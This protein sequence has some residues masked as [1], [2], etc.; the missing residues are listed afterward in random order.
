MTRRIISLDW[1]FEE[2]KRIAGGFAQHSLIVR[3]TID[4]SLQD[5]A[6]AAIETSLRQDGERYR[7][8]QAALVLIENG[9]AVRAMVGGRDYGESQF[10]RASRALRQPG[11]SF[12]I[13]TYALAMEKGMTPDSPIVDAPIFWGN[14]NPKN[15]NGGYSG[16]VDMKSA[17]ARSINTIP[18]R[19]PR[20]SSARTRSARSC[21][22]QRSSASIR[23]SAAMSPFP[24]APRRSP[25]STRR[26]PMRCSPQAASSRAVTAFL[27]SSTTMATCSMIS[28]ATRHRRSGC[29]S[30]TAND[31]MNQMLTRVPY[32]GTAR[33]AAVDG[34]L[35]GGKTGTT[36][37][38]RD[39]WFCRLYRQFHRGS[40]VRQ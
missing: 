18:V 32:V 37:A 9:G 22:L 11:S 36:Q 29:C 12:K 14:W 5:A 16:R 1:A 3:T 26:R 6:D 7:A 38:Y 35:T 23:R 10:N 31:Y 8:S 33:R 40:L 27:R 19:S 24:S 30:Q 4:P 25:S 21:R 39:A 34:V 17:F 28:P 20:T 2:V 13:F 15:Y